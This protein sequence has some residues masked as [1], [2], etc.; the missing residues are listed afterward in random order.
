MPACLQG[1]CFPTY[2]TSCIL[3]QFP[4]RTNGVLICQETHGH[5]RGFLKLV[6][7]ERPMAMAV[8]LLRLL[9]PQGHGLVLGLHRDPWPS[10]D[11]EF[12][13]PIA[14]TWPMIVGKLSFTICL[15]FHLDLRIRSLIFILGFEYGSKIGVYVYVFGRWLLSDQWLWWIFAGQSISEMG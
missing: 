4:S 13:W 8:N 3:R 5:G 15:N 14:K 2:W 10:R 11:H 6:V 7:D 9:Q 1:V 12:P